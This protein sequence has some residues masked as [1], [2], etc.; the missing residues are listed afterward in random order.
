MSMGPTAA[1]SGGGGAGGAGGAAGG[2]GA[3]SAA[4]A[5]RRY[6]EDDTTLPYKTRAFYITVLMDHRKIPSLVAELTASEKSAWPVEILRIQMVRAHD[7]DIDSRGGGFGSGSGSSGGLGAMS[8][9]AGGGGRLSLPTGL[10]TG[11]TGFPGAGSYDSETSSAGLSNDPLREGLP[12][13]NAVSQLAAATAALEGALQDP[14]IA[15]V[16][17]CGIITLY[18]EV[19]PEPVTPAAAQ[20]IVPA[21]AA[22][23]PA[24]G[25]PGTP[26]ADPAATGDPAA[27]SDPAATVPD[28]VPP[29]AE[30][31][32]PEG[33]TPAK[34][35]VPASDAP[36]AK[37]TPPAIPGAVPAAPPDAPKAPA[38]GNG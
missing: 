38:N 20:P 7:N 22:G 12:N 14:F 34:P 1:H 17:I 36:P 29:A 10:G 19:K 28:S 5:V 6:V 4:N 3:A 18:N 8:G 16:A 9:S 13:P 2:P 31:N 11:P 25:T 32:T 27:T 24:Q 26:A 15:R 21:P 33:T 35:E 23:T 37:P 30:G